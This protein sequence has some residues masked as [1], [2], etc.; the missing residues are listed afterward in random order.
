[1]AMIVATIVGIILVVF[2]EDADVATSVLDGFTMK[3]LIAVSCTTVAWVSTTFLTKPESTETLRSFYRLTRPG[4]PGWKKVVQ[5]AEADGDMIDEEN[6]GKP[7]EMPIQIL[8]V[9]IGCVVV[10]SSLFS[11]GSFLYGRM[12]AGAVLLVIAMLGTVFLFKSFGKLRAN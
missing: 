4:G 3:L 1:M 12:L 9:F 2:V 11:I 5:D 6:A 10:Y 8:L 7:W